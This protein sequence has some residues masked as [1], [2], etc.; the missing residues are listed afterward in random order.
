MLLV[1]LFLGVVAFAALWFGAGLAIGSVEKVARY[2]RVASFLVSFF[3]LG[4]LTSIS[5]ISVAFFSLLDNTPSISAGNLIGASVVIILLIIPLLAVFNKGI[6]FD[7]RAEPINFPLAFFIISLPVLL[8]LDGTL[9]TIDGAIMVIAEAFLAFTITIKNTLLNKIEDLFVHKNVNVY[10]EGFKILAGVMLIVFSCQ[11]IVDTTIFYANKFGVAPFLIGLLILAVGT[12]LP[13][14]SVLVRSTV[15]GK[16]NIALGDY[17][18]SASLN[19]LILGL[20]VLLNRAPVQITGGL[21]FNLLL[22]PIG[23]VLFLFFSRN[24]KL[25]RREGFVLFMLY[26]LFV[27]LELF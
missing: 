20:L 1:D 3:A 8:I 10:K 27:L 25:D 4:L 19:T 7:D 9:S 14:L 23:S 18:G 11:Y 12:N 21:K 16:K 13:E 2:V 5:E 26:L 17:I 6:K 24:K 22:L 15:Y